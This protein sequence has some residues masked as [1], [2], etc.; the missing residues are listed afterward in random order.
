MVVPP[1]FTTTAESDETISLDAT[2]L[3]IGGDPPSAPQ[4]ALFRV[5]D[6]ADATATLQDAPALGG[7]NA[8]TQ[9]L[10]GLAA[11]TTYRLRVTFLTSGNRR[12][13]TV[14]VI[15]VE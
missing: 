5:Q 14:I 4:A 11:G 12:A 2:A 10:R 7:G 3:L 6:G 8:I 13:M 1:T 15:C 9:R